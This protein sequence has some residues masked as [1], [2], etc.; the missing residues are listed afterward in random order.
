VRQKI[1]ILGTSLGAE[2]LADLIDEC[3]ELELT[4]FAENWDRAKCARP[5][6][7]LPVLWI[8]DLPPL[9]HTHQAVCALATNRR[10]EFV[11]PVADMGFPFAVVRHPSAHVSR[12]ATL[13]PGT[14]LSVGTIVGAHTTLGQHVIVHRG[15]MIAHHTTV[16]D[17]VTFGPGANVAGAVTI[18]DRTW[19]GMGAIITDYRTIGTGAIVG[20]GAGAVV[21]EDVPD[22]TQVV[23]NP[24]R[25][26]KDG[27]DGR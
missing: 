9:A 1:I 25:I 17:Y 27:V 3:P 2:H 15:T 19:I 12:T 14:T 13:G 20:A 23:G 8:D 11:K 7:G 22:H 4:A 10:G 6:L 18:G 24:A 5:L 16:G 26:T 21:V